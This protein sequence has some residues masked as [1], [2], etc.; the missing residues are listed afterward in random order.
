MAAKSKPTGMLCLDASSTKLKGNLVCCF[1]G[2][3]PR[4]NLWRLAT[5]PAVGN[6]TRH[7]LRAHV[8]VALQPRVFPKVSYTFS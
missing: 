8:R 2:A 3:A 5:I 7:E 4:S 1:P 6:S